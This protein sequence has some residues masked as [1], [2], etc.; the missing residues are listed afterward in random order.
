MIQLGRAGFVFLII[1]TFVLGIS[2]GYVLKF[3]IYRFAHSMLALINSPEIKADPYQS[4]IDNVFKEDIYQGELKFASI[5]SLSQINNYLNLDLVLLESYENCFD[6]LEIISIHQ[7]SFSYQN[8]I[9]PVVKLLFEYLGK[10]HE[11]YSYGRL[12]IALNQVKY[13][14]LIIPGTGKNQSSAIYADDSTNYHF[15]ILNALTPLGGDVF[16]LVKPNEDFL[17]FHNGEKKINEFA[18]FNHYLSNKSS[19]AASY[20]LDAF[21]FMKWAK[22]AYKHTCVAGLSQGGGAALYVSVK[23][24]PDIAIVASGHSIIFNDVNLSNFSQIHAVPDYAELFDS[25]KLCNLL[26]HTPTKYLFT[27]GKTE[28]NYYG[29]ES[30]DSITASLIG[31]IN[32]VKIAIHRGGHV[33]PVQEIKDFLLKVTY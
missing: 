28:M 12:P 11:A 18:I 5:D 6:R 2:T 23:A 24:K 26:Q 19:Y 30:R 8:K 7:D 16:V 27:W 1:C 20:L 21:A 31:D 25:K 10:K 15:G 14:T 9:L 3:K 29:I 33:F 17:A 4:L 13:A 32:H 22:T